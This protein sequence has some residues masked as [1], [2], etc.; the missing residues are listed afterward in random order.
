MLLQVGIKMHVCSKLNG[1]PDRQI[2]LVVT[3]ILITFC[4]VKNSLLQSKKNL[5]G[6][7]N[8]MC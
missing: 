7:V 5:D 2:T 8:S 3:L 4:E 6:A 1:I